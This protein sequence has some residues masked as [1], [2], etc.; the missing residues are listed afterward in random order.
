MFNFMTMILVAYILY[1]TIYICISIYTCI[2][3]ELGQQK[4]R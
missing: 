3:I 4:R 2:I 1:S